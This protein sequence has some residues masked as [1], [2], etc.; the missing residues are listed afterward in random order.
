M[1]R[2][3][4]LVTPDNWGEP[5]FHIPAGFQPVIRAAPPTRLIPIIAFCR[6]FSGHVYW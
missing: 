2:I 3:Y 5:F 4:L 1:P 6:Y